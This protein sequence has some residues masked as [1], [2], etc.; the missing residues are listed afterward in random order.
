MKPFIAKI[1]AGKDLT[2]K[3]MQ[4]AKRYDHV[5]VND[6]LK[7]AFCRLESIVLQ[8]LSPAALRS[9]GGVKR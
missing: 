9:A 1:Q 4:E 7:T 8:E 3:E 5:V 2:Q 6:R